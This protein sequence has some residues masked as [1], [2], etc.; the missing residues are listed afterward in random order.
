MT[1]C[2][3]NNLG[4]DMSLTEGFKDFID[5]DYIH[6]LIRDR[7]ENLPKCREIF[8]KSLSKQPLSVEETAELLA[9]TSEEG[10]H[11]LFETARELKRNVYGNRI[12]LFAPLYIGNYCINDCTYCGFRRS[13][14]TTV[15]HT[16]SEEQLVNEVKSL[17]NEGHKRLILVYGE[18]PKYTPEFIAKTVKLTYATKTNNGKGEI[19]R[20]NI[21]A[22]PLDIAGYKIVKE[23]GI[24]TFQ[25]FQETYHKET[26]AKYHPAGTQKGDYMWRLNAMDRAFEGGIDDMGIGALFGLYDWRFE[27]LGLV[28]HALHLQQR[29]GVGPHT[30]SFPRI[31]PA[32]GLDIELPY[33]VSDSEFERL[34]AILRLA[35][36]YTGLIMTARESKAIRDKVMEFGVSQIDAGTK[37]EIGGYQKERQDKEQTLNEEQFQVGDTRDLDE[38]IHW[39]INRDYI[40]SFCTSCYRVGRTGEHFMEF[41]IPG[42]IKRFCTRNGLLTLAEYLEDYSSEATKKDGYALIE[43]EIAKMTN[44]EQ[45]KSLLE[46]LDRIRNKGER[47]LLY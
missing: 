11:E 33:R 20:V 17:E 36:P 46:R 27:V 39:L 10:L 37:L 47:D 42:F 45:K 26:Y 19:R 16:L 29:Y 15:R 18:H 41:A 34:V 3:E 12:V 32:N 21:N 30:I 31:Q 14:R 22:A 4:L 1:C 35:V 28:T 8:K 7:K 6:S 23:A 2:K 13:L 38:V 40:P 9:I 5:D 24:G 43:R 44:E 25:V